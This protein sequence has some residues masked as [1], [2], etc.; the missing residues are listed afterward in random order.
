MKSRW[1]RVLPKGTGIIPYIW[2]LLYI[3]P[4]YFIFQYS[5][6]NRIWIGIVLMIAFVIASQLSQTTNRTL[7]Y[8]WTF[9]Q[10]GISAVMTLLYD[11]VYLAF[12]IAY[13]I[14]NIRMR[15][16]FFVLY[17]IHLTCVF[18][19]INYSF[20]TQNGVFINQFPFIILCLIGSILLP[21]NTYTQIRRGE[22][23]EKLE[24]ANKRIAELVIQEERQRIS[25]DLHDTLGQKL[26]LIGLKSDLAGRLVHKNPD[27]ARNE[28]KDVNLTAR[29]ALKEVRQLVSKMRGVKVAD[30]IVHARQMLEA[31]HIDFQYSGDVRLADV[32]PFIQHVLSMCVK[33]TVTNIVKHSQATACDMLIEQS[34][35][36]TLIRIRDNGIGIP[37]HIPSGN[38][39]Q[40]MRERLEFINGTV[41]LTSQKGTI[42]TIRVPRVNKQKEAG[43]SV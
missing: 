35:T 8:V 7:L 41:S 11:Y 9:V 23:Q 22:L 40:G 13:F 6:F 38:G 14:G 33:E 20:I 32:P 4:F 16:H 29:T 3:L 10:I 25:R 31:A 2:A 37:A 34:P 30:E 18:I 26:S 39:L 12:F 15:V 28:M 36:D 19:T 27:Q 43:D 1:F 24:Y 17:A 21:V 42:V 5:S